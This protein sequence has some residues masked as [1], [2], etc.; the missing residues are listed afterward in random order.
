MGLRAGKPSTGLAV[1]SFSSATAPA[2][3]RAGPQAPATT[4]PRPRRAGCL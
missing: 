4:R 3:R 1:Q 2:G